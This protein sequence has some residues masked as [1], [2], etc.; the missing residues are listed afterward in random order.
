VF[1]FVAIDFETANEKRCSPCSLGLVMI[2]NGSVVERRAWLLRPPSSFFYFN[3]INIRIH[4][5]DEEMV[6]DKPEL[7]DLWDE[8]AP[9][10][11]GNIVC[12]HNASFDFSVLRRTLEVY[13]IPLPNC[14]ILCSVAVSRRAWPELV[15][16]SLPIVASR[17]NLPL[18]HHDAGDDAACSAE[19]LLRACNEHDIEFL[20]EMEKRL[21]VFPGYL[22]HGVY[23]CCSTPRSTKPLTPPPSPKEC[24]RNRN[25]P[26]FGKQ[27]VFTGALKL[28]TRDTAFRHV[29]LAGGHPRSGMSGNI[30]YLVMGVQDFSRFRNG[31]KSS[32]TSK[33]EELRA[34]G[35]DI[36]IIS[37]EDFTKMLCSGED[38][39]P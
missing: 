11:E 36:E 2:K 27:V 20:D 8:I 24:G 25:H 9:F 4:G 32:K 10:L 12:A 5:I 30:D 23:S 7:V 34:S 15:S 37:E 26:L 17:L 29:A 1:D 39:E 16:F 21:E 3:P 18:Q 13:D 19:I 31:Q 38:M 14:D 22:R 33:A 28:M 35:Y 6:A